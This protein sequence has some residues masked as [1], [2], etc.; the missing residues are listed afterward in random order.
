MKR[1][2]L[3]EEERRRGRERS[4]LI[5]ILRAA[6]GCLRLAKAAGLSL[7]RVAVRERGYVDLGPPGILRKCPPL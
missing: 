5:E 1:S 7:L 6:R 3:D 4:L 2:R